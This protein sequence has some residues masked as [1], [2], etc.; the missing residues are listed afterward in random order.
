MSFKYLFAS[1]HF[2]NIGL[3]TTKLAILILYRRIFVVKGMQRTSVVLMV[4]VVLYGLSCIISGI[5][6]CIPVQAFWD[7]TLMVRLP[8]RKKDEKR[9]LIKR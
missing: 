7:R 6:Y 4:I 2:Y 5:F 3:T 1:I 9:L 8:S